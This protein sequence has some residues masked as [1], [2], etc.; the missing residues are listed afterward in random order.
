MKKLLKY[1]F[2]DNYTS[3]LLINVL[4][5][6]SIIG[7]SFFSKLSFYENRFLGIFVVIFYI[8]LFICLGLWF[9][10]LVLAILNSINKKLFC[11]QGYLTF[12]LPLSIDT[13]LIAKI[14]I[15]LF[16]IAISL[17]LFYLAL[18]IG[19]NINPNVQNIISSIYEYVFSNPLNAFLSHLSTLVSIALV[20]I[21]FLFILSLLNIGKIKKHRFIAGIFI[22]L[23]LEIIIGVCKSIIWG[24]LPNF[25]VDYLSQITLYP[26]VQFFTFNIGVNV[27]EFIIFYFLTRFLIKNKLELE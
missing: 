19:A 24:L 7:A 4:V 5:F 9:V 21:E 8:I 26:L 10:V 20:L 2:L 15:N 12:S 1:D 17:V 13:I 27:I 22:F 3:I 14:L 16:W 23:G 25:Y 6:F 18:Y 11:P